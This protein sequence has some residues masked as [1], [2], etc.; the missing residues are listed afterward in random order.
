M[1]KMPHPIPTMWGK[2]SFLGPSFFSTNM[3]Y[4]KEFLE[5]HKETQQSFQYFHPILHG[6]WGAEKQKMAIKQKL[7]VV[8]AFN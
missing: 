5:K 8:K 2:G 4:F 1:R 3:V 6:G 7:L